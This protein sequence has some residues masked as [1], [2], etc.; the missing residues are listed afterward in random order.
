MKYEEDKKLVDN[1]L[2]IFKEYYGLMEIRERTKS[3][4]SK[5]I[6]A[7]KC[8]LNSSIDF[9]WND[10]ESWNYIRYIVVKKITG[11]Q[12]VMSLFDFPFY[13]DI[14]VNE[15]FSSLAFMC[16]DD[17]SEKGFKDG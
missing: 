5:D 13:C 12:K 16:D 2:E 10:K 9:H 17:E 14:D 6:I 8:L 3:I 4:R 1:L 11:Y 7:S 15:I